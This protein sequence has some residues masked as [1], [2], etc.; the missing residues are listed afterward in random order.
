MVPARARACSR[1]KGFLTKV[2]P[3]AQEHDPVAR[4][5]ESGCPGAQL[6]ITLD[7]LPGSTLVVA[8]EHVSG[9]QLSIT[10]HI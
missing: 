3:V 5:H 4:E 7:R 6:S 8:R 1:M 2:L 10:G 9:A